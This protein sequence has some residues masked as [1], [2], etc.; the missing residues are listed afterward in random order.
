V[1]VG[2]PAPNS[3]PALETEVAQTEVA[4]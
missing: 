3:C 4:Q 2:A 1:S